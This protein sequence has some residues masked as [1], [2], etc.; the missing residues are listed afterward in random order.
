MTNYKKFGPKIYKT[1]S[2]RE[3]AKPRPP[4]YKPHPDVDEKLLNTPF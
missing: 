4:N 1:L 3:K 2:S